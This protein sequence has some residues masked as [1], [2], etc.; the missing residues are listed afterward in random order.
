M[1]DWRSRYWR[2]DLHERL[3][4]IKERKDRKM[5]EATP[6]TSGAT[7][8]IADLNESMG[9]EFEAG[10]VLKGRPAREPVEIRVVPLGWGVTVDDDVMPQDGKLSKGEAIKLA[11]VEAREQTPAVVTVLAA[12]GKIVRKEYF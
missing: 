10:G 4:Q 5:T 12:T 11:K 2:E 9:V 6:T 8:E 7:T 3:K 1:M